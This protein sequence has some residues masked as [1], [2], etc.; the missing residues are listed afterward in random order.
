MARQRT[1]FVTNK[2][3]RSADHSVGDLSESAVSSR[4]IPFS[5]RIAREQCR[6]VSS[7]YNV[8]FLTFFFGPVIGPSIFHG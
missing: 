5:D 4:A 8:L 2:M 6:S 7:G 1:R 3:R